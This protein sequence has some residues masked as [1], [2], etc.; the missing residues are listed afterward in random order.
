MARRTPLLRQQIQRALRPNQT[1]R[2]LALGVLASLPITPL[3]AAEQ[4]LQWH[5]KPAGD[6]WACDEKPAPGPAYKRPPH[7]TSAA[8]NGPR[9]TRGLSAAEID[10]VAEEE[11]TP[12]QLE[13]MPAGCCGSYIAPERS[14]SE[15]TL[16]PEQAPLRAEADSSRWLQQNTAVLQGDVKLTQGYRQLQADSAELDKGSNTGI[17]SGNVQMREPGVLITSERA[18]MNMDTGAAELENA[19]YLLHDAHLRGSSAAVKMTPEKVLT[20]ED[21]SFTRCEPDGNAWSLHSSELTLDPNIGE[22][23]GKHVRLHV[24]GVPVFYTPYLRFPIGDERKSGF[25]FPS[26]SSSDNGGVDVS[27]P[28]Y[29]N[30]AP[31]YDMTLSPRVISDRGE[32]LETEIRHMSTHFD[33][34]VSTAWLADDSGGDDQDLE[35]LIDDG[36][37]TEEEAYPFRGEDRWLLGVEQ[38]GGRQSRWFTQIDYTAVSDVDYFRDLGT[39]SLEVNSTSQLKK[40][41]TAGYR[42]DHW[43][44]QAEATEYQKLWDDAEQ[45]YKQLPRLTLDGHYRMPADFEL[46]LDHDFTAFDHRDKERDGL[47]TGERLRLDYALT[48]DQ[49]WMWGFFRPGVKLKHLS[50]RLDDDYLQAGA[51]DT[52]SFT[53]PQGSLDTGLFFEREGNLFGNGYVQTFEPRLFYFYS[54]RE[55]QDE[56]I[57]VGTG[58][59]RTVDF[60]TN[61][62]TF[63]YSQLFRDSRFSGS[64]R[65]DDD[66]RLS[67]GLTS[68]FIDAS[69]GIERFSASLG[70]VFYH[71]DRAIA[72][73]LTEAQALAQ[74]ENQ[75]SDSDFAAQVSARLGKY[76]RFNSEVMWD[77][78]N[79]DRVSRGNASLRYI[80]EQYR[81]FN[82]SY[83]YDRIPP[84]PSDPT[85]LD[86]D[87][88]LNEEIEQS[89]E[90]GDL[91]FVWPIAGDWNAIGRANYDFTHQRELETLIGV[92]YNDCCY[93]VRLVARKWL[94]NANANVLESLDLEEDRGIFLEF[95]LKGMGSIG[96]KVSGILS[97]GIVGYEQRDNG[98]Q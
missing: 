32:M 8:T 22:G 62:L 45:Q 6:G 37:I 86:G 48:W 74:A 69:T 88:I 44:L 72:I 29:L 41:G 82:L 11:L 20:L 50:Y 98:I 63:G 56:L 83:R 80:D 46:Q 47:I 89:I 57:N 52:P 2:L 53:V 78:D 38:F 77:A 7:N 28:Y 1:P 19:T 79:S 35:D 34:V 25:L 55:N 4:N 97:D 3:Q 42:G 39:T 71:D 18:K 26:I 94:D 27:V 21:G 23:W 92:E 76:L 10:W 14:D 73:D 87:G 5:C 61:D 58:R 33:T 24:A 43:L 15:A 67:V 30:L 65:I 17:L 51:N 85:D 93:R 84:L 81:I 70:Q 16:D 91:S 36:V 60:D 96:S 68:R 40:Y 12:E 13:Q 90:Q 75:R 49:Q 59:L 66:N 31:N 54:D 9:S 95:Q 64:D